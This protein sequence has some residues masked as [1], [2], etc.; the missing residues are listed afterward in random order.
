MIIDASGEHVMEL[1]LPSWARILRISCPVNK[2]ETTTVFSEDD[3]KVTDEASR[4]IE[5]MG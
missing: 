5:V 1:I 3:T 2:L 4:A